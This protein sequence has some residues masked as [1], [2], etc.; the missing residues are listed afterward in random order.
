MNETA[1][2]A[3]I[4]L[5]A[6]MGS[7]ETGSLLVIVFVLPLVLSFS[8]LWLAF[9]ALREVEKAFGTRFDRADA[10]RA[11]IKNCLTACVTLRKSDI[12]R[13]LDVARAYETLARN[14]QMMM[15][16]MIEALKENV[17]ALEG[18]KTKMDCL[19]R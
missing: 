15:D 10:D 7:W 6:R 17:K 13:H 4:E 9:R 8:S 2:L 19:L 3:I 14:Q 1:T 5:L 18:V 12:D 11:E 16:S